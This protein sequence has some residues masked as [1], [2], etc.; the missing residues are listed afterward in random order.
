MIK[1]IMI[2]YPE[3]QHIANKQFAILLFHLR[4]VVCLFGRPVGIWIQNAFKI[5]FLWAENEKKNQFGIR[6]DLVYGHFD[7]AGL[8]V[9]REQEQI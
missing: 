7:G 9:C 6:R 2:Y 8:F 1:C 3:K 5:F 4:V